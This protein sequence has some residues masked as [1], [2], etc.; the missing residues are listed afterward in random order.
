MKERLQTPE[1]YYR[2]TPFGKLMFGED[3]YLLP[4][5][6]DDEGI[7]TY[8]FKGSVPLVSWVDWEYIARYFVSDKDKFFKLRILG[9]EV[10][11]LKSSND[12]RLKG[13]EY[14]GRVPRSAIAY[15]EICTWKKNKPKVIKDLT[16]LL[17]QNGY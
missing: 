12:P 17:K 10:E 16:S 2:V 5:R 13:L 14:F 15:I 11:S 1:Y 6:R 4:H 9:S 7:R 8:F 3:Q